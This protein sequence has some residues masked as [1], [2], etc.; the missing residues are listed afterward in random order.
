MY[1]KAFTAVGV[2]NT[3]V[4]HGGLVS[5]VDVPKHL[6]AVVINCDTTEG[7]II[8]GWIGN[9]LVLEIYDY[10]LDTQEVSAA[11]TP[12]LSAMKMG[13]IPLDLDVPAGQVFKIGIRSGAVANDIFGAYEYTETAT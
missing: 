5:L 9:K 2:I 8:E 6:N 1:Y 3:T 12:P 7:N 13:R 11:D 10:C 4:L